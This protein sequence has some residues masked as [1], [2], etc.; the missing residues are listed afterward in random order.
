MDQPRATIPYD[1]VEV[2]AALKAQRSAAPELLVPLDVALTWMAGRYGLS[3]EQ[4]G[5]KPAQ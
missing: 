4:P 3:S 5:P 2:G 1:G